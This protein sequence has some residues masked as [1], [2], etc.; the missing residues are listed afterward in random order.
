MNIKRGKLLLDCKRRKTKLTFHTKLSAQQRFH[1]SKD[2][3]SFWSVEVSTQLK[4]RKFNRKL[5]GKLWNLG[6]CLFST[7]CP[8]L[9]SYFPAEIKNF[10]EC[11][12]GHI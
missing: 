6:L 1:M 11:V 2:N 3:G 4:H 12:K 5:K 7:E 9:K 10:A 8:Y